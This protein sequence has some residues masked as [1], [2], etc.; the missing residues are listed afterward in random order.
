VILNQ[1]RSIGSDFGGTGD[2]MS[3]LLDICA[4]LATSGAEYF[5]SS[6]AAHAASG[7]WN[8]SGFSIS[9][10]FYPGLHSSYSNY[11]P[12]YIG[13]NRYYFG[14][15]RPRP[16][17]TAAAPARQPRTHLFRSIGRKSA[18]RRASICRATDE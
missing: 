5:S 6:A 3:K 8:N 4:A 1:W 18:A 14:G 10:Q 12:T 13:G 2:Q 16:R 17:G 11:S 9:H 7:Y 15:L